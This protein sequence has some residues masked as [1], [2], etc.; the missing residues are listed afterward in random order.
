MFRAQFRASAG[1]VAPLASEAVNA[2]SVGAE[3]VE[4]HEGLSLGGLARWIGGPGR[5]LSDPVSKGSLA[6]IVGG[7]SPLPYRSRAQEA[8]GGGG[9]GRVVHPRGV[10]EGRLT[11]EIMS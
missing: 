6:S 8:L 1:A 4:P 2:V 11:P 10:S 9:G 7:D 3:P 5:T